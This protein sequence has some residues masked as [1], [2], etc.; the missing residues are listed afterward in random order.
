MCEPLS[1][2]WKYLEFFA[3]SVL[4]YC[5]GDISN[6][7]LWFW[8][9]TLS[10]LLSYLHVG[11]VNEELLNTRAVLAHVEKSVVNLLIDARRP[12]HQCGMYLIMK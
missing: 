8:S 4:S 9:N 3:N 5:L 2:I 10:M 7:S 11:P 12:V 6:L 1:S